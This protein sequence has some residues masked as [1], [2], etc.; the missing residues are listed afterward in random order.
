[1]QGT[2]KY[3]IIYKIRGKRERKRAVLISDP[4]SLAGDIEKLLGKKTNKNY[5]VLEIRQKLWETNFTEYIASQVE[6]G[7]IPNTNEFNDQIFDF[8]HQLNGIFK[9]RN[10]KTIGATVDYDRMCII[11][12]R[13]IEP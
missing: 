11:V 6:K 8:A 10:I 9:K 13:R 3:Q 4:S 1:M 5:K 7:R 12:Y 2:E